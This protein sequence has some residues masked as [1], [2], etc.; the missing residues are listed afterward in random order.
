KKAELLFDLLQQAGTENIAYMHA[1][2]HQKRRF[3]TLDAFES[4][5]SR[6][7]IATD[8]LSRGLDI[9]DVTHVINFDLPELAENYIHR[10]GRTGRFGKKG[11]AI[12]FIE[13]KDL[14]MLQAL[15][16]MMGTEL[17]EMSLPMDYEQSE[18][19]RPE[20]KES[21]YM[22]DYL[23]QTVSKSDGGAFHEKLEKNKKVNV[24]FDYE[25]AMKKKY[26][27]QYRPKHAR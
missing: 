19:L 12:S 11:T 22:P 4:G 16:A 25:A 9:K 13:Q 18:E 3:D 1:N 15:E 26:G 20:E 17:N 10:I 21:I 24:R 14:E 27:K 6:I 23:G 5:D 2:K 7:L 8:L